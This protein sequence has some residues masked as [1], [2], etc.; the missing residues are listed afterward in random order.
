[1]RQFGADFGVF[2]QAVLGHAL[3]HLGHP[4]RAVAASTQALALAAELAHPFSRAIALAYDAMLH[5]FLG[6]RVIVAARAAA[7]VDLSA[8]HGFA[9]YHAWGT[10]LGGW[11]LA[12][13][14][15]VERGIELVRGGIAAIRATGAEL[16]RPYFLSLLAEPSIAIGR[17]AHGLTL[18]DDALATAERTGEHW[19]SADL[20]RLRG[21]LLRARGAPDAEVEA[22]LRQACEI[23]DAQQ[24]RSLGLRATLSLA[25][26][27]GQPVSAP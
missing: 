1:M 16:R 23:A 15:D 13:G 18:V 2:S 7:V 10:I 25:R 5:Q 11:A 9:Y 14:P 12:Q 20:H 26:L 17:A 8:A 27:L 19:R 4:E 22:S 3:W 21:E 24:A 6:D